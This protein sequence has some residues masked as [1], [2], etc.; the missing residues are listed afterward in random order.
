MLLPPYTQV[1][2]GRP[3]V[4]AHETGP[5]STHPRWVPKAHGI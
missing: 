2:P 4:A 5:I 3:E 1:V